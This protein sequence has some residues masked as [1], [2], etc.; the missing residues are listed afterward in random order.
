MSDANIYEVD[1]Y[2]KGRVIGK[3]RAKSEGASAQLL[4][5]E[6]GCNYSYTSH[7]NHD[8]SGKV[9]RITILTVTKEKS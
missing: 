6:P 1:L 3:V 4:D 5:L 8:E 7:V 2:E 9:S